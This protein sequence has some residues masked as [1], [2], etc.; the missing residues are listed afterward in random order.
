MFAMSCRKRLPRG[1][2]LIELMVAI[3]IIALLTGL[4][5]P[6]L[7]KARAMG[8]QAKELAAADSLLTGYTLWGM[9][10]RGKLFSATDYKPDCVV[11]NDHGD[12]IWDPGAGSGDGSHM[13]YSWRLAPYFDYEIEGALLVNE[14]AR[15]LG[16]YDPAS[17]MLYNYLTNLVPS[18]GMNRKLGQAYDAEDNPRPL[19]HELDVRQPS[20]L[21]VVASAHN[22]GFPDY[23]RGNRDVQSAAGP[24]KEANPASLGNIHLRWNRKAVIGF[25]DGHA[26]LMDEREILT[27]RGLWEGR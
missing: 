13:G 4:L 16:E 17:P 15:M 23:L 19:R 2:T 10:H 1:F 11:R 14:Q 22:V 3:S 5:L 7:A 8:K 26:G 12:V 27:E 9:D 20:Q 21:L 25:L 24:Y 6:V 18:L